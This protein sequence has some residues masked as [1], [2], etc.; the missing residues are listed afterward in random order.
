MKTKIIICVLMS[1]LMLLLAACDIHQDKQ[2]DIPKMK[3]EHVKVV[4]YKILHGYYA[5]VFLDTLTNTRMFFYKE[6]MVVL[7]KESN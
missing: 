6:A 3:V 1:V 2:V 5:V 7:P 4:D